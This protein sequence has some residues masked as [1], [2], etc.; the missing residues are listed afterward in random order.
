MSFQEIVNTVSCYTFQRL[1]VDGC[2]RSRK[3]A[4]L[5]CSVT[6]HHN[7]VQQSRVLTQMDIHRFTGVVDLY[8]L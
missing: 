8:L 2:D 6:N 4:D 7:L 1:F 5:S 3:V